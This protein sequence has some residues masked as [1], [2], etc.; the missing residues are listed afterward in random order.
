MVPETAEAEPKELL[1]RGTAFIV[2]IYSTW[3]WSLEHQ[4]I[5]FC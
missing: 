1:M 4:L 5:L 3:P 2:D